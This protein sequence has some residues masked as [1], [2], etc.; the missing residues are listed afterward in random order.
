MTQD[1][2]F[3]HKM[4]NSKTTYVTTHLRSDDSFSLYK[5]SNTIICDY[6]NKI[7]KKYHYTSD[8]KMINLLE[9]IL[10]KSHKI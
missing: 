7:L 4:L 6:Y 9:I 3:F 10:Q 5:T 8:S 1:Q 2:E